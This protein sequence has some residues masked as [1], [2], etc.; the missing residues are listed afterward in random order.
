[1]QWPFD[2]LAAQDVVT[3]YIDTDATN[4]HLSGGH[5]VQTVG[6]GENL[7]GVTFDQLKTAV[8]GFIHIDGDRQV[9]AITEVFGRD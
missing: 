3:I 1:M 5:A 4:E 2:Y 9:A 6:P 7:F 8:S